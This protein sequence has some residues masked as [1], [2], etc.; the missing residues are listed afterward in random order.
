MNPIRTRENA[1]RESEGGL[2]GIPG[3]GRVGSGDWDRQGGGIRGQGLS[4]KE[5]RAR[6]ERHM[7]RRGP[8]RRGTKQPEGEEEAVTITEG[9]KAS[10]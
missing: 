1:P 9:R 5:T 4:R 6:E 3:Y 10:K 7:D 8:G 2:G